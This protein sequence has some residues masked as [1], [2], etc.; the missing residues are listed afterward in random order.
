MS[1]KEP[2]SSRL[3][4][5]VTAA[6]RPIWRMRRG[7]TLGSQ[8][9]VIDEAGRILLVRHSYRAGWFFP[10]GGVEWGETLEEALARE[11]EEELG[12]RSQDVEYITHTPKWQYYH[13]PK[14]FLRHHVKP[15]CIGQKQK[16][17]LLRLIS[18]DSSV[19]LDYA[20]RPEF[21]DWQW[22]D[23]WQPADKIIDFKKQVYLSVL[24]EFRQAV[25]ARV[26]HE[27]T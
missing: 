8:G 22:V 15:L 20:E 25:K 23:Y 9:A 13:L 1:T 7:M 21:D 5:V 14:R 2:R 26:S 24:K 10:G 16:W 4:R 19:H 3:S 12:L 6:I 27:N 18:D 17:F 11:L